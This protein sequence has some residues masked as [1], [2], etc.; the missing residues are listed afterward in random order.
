MV[1]VDFMVNRIELVGY[2]NHFLQH[3]VA[4]RIVQTEH[5]P[6]PISNEAS[7][8]RKAYFSIGIPAVIFL[9]IMVEMLALVVISCQ[10]L[11]SYHG[12]NAF[13]YI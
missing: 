4:G 12:E 13:C 9:I 3:L 1:L 11:L 10:L 5:A 2:T 7:L 6:K 8:T